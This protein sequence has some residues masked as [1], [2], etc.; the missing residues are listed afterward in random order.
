MATRRSELKAEQAYHVTK[1]DMF[2]WTPDGVGGFW[3]DT[4]EE[5]EDQHGVG[6]I[7]YIDE[8]LDY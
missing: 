2:F 4:L 6:D 8:L 7:I 3:Y 5:M 1:D